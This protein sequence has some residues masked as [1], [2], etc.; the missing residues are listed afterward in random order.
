MHFSKTYT[1]LLSTLP[2]ELRN[3]ALEYRKVRRFDSRV[4]LTDPDAFNSQLK[5]LINQTVFELDSLGLGPSV[6]QSLHEP[7][8]TRDGTPPLTVDSDNKHATIVY[9][10]VW[11]SSVP[12]PRLRL[13]SI[14]LSDVE[15]HHNSIIYHVDLLVPEQLLTRITTAETPSPDDCVDSYALAPL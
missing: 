4:D 6:L 13:S 1:Q 15:T 5:R 9:E 11:N 12:E 10:I 2:P 3:N 14:S 7:R 8:N